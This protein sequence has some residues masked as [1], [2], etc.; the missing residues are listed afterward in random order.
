MESLKTKYS[1]TNEDMCKSKDTMKNTV[2]MKIHDYVFSLL[3]NELKK[4]S[5][6]QSLQYHSY[7]QQFYL[8]NT[9]PKHTYLLLRLRCNMM[10]TIHNRPYMFGNYTKCR[11]CKTGDESLSHIVMYHSCDPHQ[12]NEELLYGDDPVNV[13]YSMEIAETVIRFL[14]DVESKEW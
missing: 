2:K 1:I 14:D 12:V 6:V 3:K 8:T 4:H 10:N 11:L 5:K 9:T 13:K 7:Q